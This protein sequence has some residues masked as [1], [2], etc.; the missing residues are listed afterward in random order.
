[1]RFFSLE[2]FIGRSL[3]GIIFSQVGGSDYWKGL[4]TTQ[5]WN[6]PRTNLWLL[7]SGPHTASQAPQWHHLSSPAFWVFI[8]GFCRLP[9][10]YF[11][12][13]FPSLLFRQVKVFIFS[14]SFSTF[15]QV[16][17]RN[18]LLIMLNLYSV[19]SKI[20][21]KD[22]QNMGKR[23]SLQTYNYQPSLSCLFTMSMKY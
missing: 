3:I 1:M 7:D 23:F 8:T 4:D 14:H 6:L 5:Q 20:L 13:L 18:L 11:R 17:Q 21:N 16:L 15:S 12:V 22:A 2:M 9:S 19:T 10:C